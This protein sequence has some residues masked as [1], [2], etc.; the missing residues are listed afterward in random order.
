M[1]WCHAQSYRHII[2][3]FHRAIEGI[4]IPYFR[5]EKGLKRPKPEIHRPRVW[6]FHQDRHAR[7]L[8]TLRTHLLAV[9]S[10]KRQ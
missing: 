8:A 3:N 2:G 4:H 5:F 6:F 10:P 1:L 7:P 9:H